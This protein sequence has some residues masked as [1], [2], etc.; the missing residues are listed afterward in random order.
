[1]KNSLWQLPL[2]AV[3]VVGFVL[4]LYGPS[5]RVCTVC[6]LVCFKCGAYT[7]TVLLFS[8]FSSMIELRHCKKVLSANYLPRVGKTTKKEHLRTCLP[9]RFT[10]HFPLKRTMADGCWSSSSPA[11]HLTSKENKVCE[12]H[13]EPH[14][15]ALWY[16][17]LCTQ[18]TIFIW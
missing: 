16:P 1:M 9:C 15:S 18:I 14:S 12:K 2:V 3:T 6:W 17:Q 11:R 10:P 13:G 8:S 5:G 4:S 7:F